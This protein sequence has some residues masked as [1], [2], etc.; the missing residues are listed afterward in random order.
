MRCLSIGARD[1]R[2]ARPAQLCGG[3]PS[4]HSQA[5]FPSRS[6]RSPTRSSPAMADCSPG[7]RTASSGRAATRATAG[8]GCAWTRRWARSRRSLTAPADC[9]APGPGRTKGIRD[10]TAG[11]AA[12]CRGARASAGAET[13]A[14]HEHNPRIRSIHHPSGRGDARRDRRRA[15]GARGSAWT[16][17]TTSKLHAWPSSRASPRARP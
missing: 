9:R 15:R 6:R 2:S 7:S 3:P 16:S 12:G 4:G 10:S 11:P 5:G 14:T 13:G 8:R 1:P 17:S